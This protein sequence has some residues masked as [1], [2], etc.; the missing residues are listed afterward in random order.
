MRELTTWTGIDDALNRARSLVR[1][2]QDEA[3]KQA[4]L[5]ALALDPTCFPALNELATLAYETGHRAAARTAYSQAV[6]CHPANP[7]GR[8]NLGNLLFNAI[9]ALGF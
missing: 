2:S 9:L 5:E 7:I 8:V 1:H 6:A 3:A 4:Y